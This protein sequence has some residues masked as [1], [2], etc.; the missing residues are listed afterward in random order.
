MCTQHCTAV[1]TTVLLCASG[2]LHCAWRLHGLL[3]CGGPLGRNCCHCPISKR[4]DPHKRKVVV[5]CM[6]W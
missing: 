6:A 4:L 5:V 2:R 3:G 1:V